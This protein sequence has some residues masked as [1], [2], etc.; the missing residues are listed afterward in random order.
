M[1]RRK[2]TVSLE[3]TLT[4]FTLNNI[5]VTSFPSLSRVA[6]HPVQTRQKEAPHRTSDTKTVSG[7]SGGKYTPYQTFNCTPYQAALSSINPRGVPPI[8]AHIFSSWSPAFQ[9]TASTPSFLNP[10][11]KSRIQAY[12]RTQPSP[13]QELSGRPNNR[14]CSKYST[15]SSSSQ[16]ASAL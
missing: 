11:P 7:P 2:V 16:S 10:S 14:P 4:S 1:K 12:L 5:L 3:D 8:K 9:P 6:K 13:T 15:S